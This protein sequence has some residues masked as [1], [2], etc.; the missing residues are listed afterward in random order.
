MYDSRLPLREFVYHDGDTTEWDKASV[1]PL[2]HTGWICAEK[3]DEVWGM[4]H[5]DPQWAHAYSLAVQ[6]ENYVLYR[7]KIEEMKAQLPIG[8]IQ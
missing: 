3:G 8:P 7:Q 4:L 6:T 5:I 2:G 1:A